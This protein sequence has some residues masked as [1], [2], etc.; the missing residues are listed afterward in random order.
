MIAPLESAGG[1]GGF[2]RYGAGVVVGRD[3]VQEQVLRA[4]RAGQDEALLLAVESTN[5]LRRLI[6]SG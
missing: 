6:A 5:C 2:R 1:V 4:V 3:L